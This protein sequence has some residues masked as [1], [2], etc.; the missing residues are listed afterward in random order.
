MVRILRSLAV[1]VEAWNGVFAGVTPAVTCCACRGPHGKLLM[2]SSIDG[3]CSVVAFDDG[4]L[5]EEL[6]S[7]GAASVVPAG[8]APD[9]GAA[10]PTDATATPQ[11]TPVVT[12]PPAI[13]PAITVSDAPDNAA[14]AAPTG[15]ALEAVGKP[16][17][18]LLFESDGDE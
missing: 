12:A 2:V 10:A 1:G 9:T 6:P 4:E 18:S 7:K 16:L 15:A 14:G 13:L 11:P 3:Y 17:P 5:G 8:S